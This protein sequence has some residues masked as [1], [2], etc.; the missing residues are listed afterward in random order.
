MK[1]GKYAKNLAKIQVKGTFR[2]RDIRR[3]VLPKFIEIN[4]LWRRH[5]A[6]HPDGHQIF[7]SSTTFLNPLVRTNP[8]WKSNSVFFCFSRLSRPAGE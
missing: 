5:A 6:A 3:N 4:S 2:I 1:G 7:D 8:V